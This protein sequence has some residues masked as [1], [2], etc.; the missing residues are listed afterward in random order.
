M[1]DTNAYTAF[2]M[3]DPQ[4]LNTLRRADEIGVS[5]VVLAELAAGFRGGSQEARNRDEL[6]EFL[7]TPRVRQVTIDRDT[8][9][10]YASIYDR[11]RRKG[12]PIPTNDLWIAACAM[13]N[14]MALVSADSHFAEID[15]LLLA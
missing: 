2:K 10:H 14:G 3:N 6:V 13:Q 15:G 8:A 9:E 7:S 11:L 1:I 12:R 4:V 5:P